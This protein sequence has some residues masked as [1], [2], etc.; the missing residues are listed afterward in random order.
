MKIIARLFFLFFS[1][2]VALFVAQYVVAGFSVALSFESYVRIVLLFSAIVFFLRPLIKLV[3]SPIIIITFGLGIIIVNA[4]VLYVLTLLTP[5]V[6][7]TG[8]DAL[9]Y[10]TV[11][12]GIV[13]LVLHFAAK[14][15][16]SHSD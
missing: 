8:L 1:N 16:Y 3:L 13:N 2:T 5:D 6:F 15:L 9:L 4:I 10:A 11:V 7:V 12:I 14:L